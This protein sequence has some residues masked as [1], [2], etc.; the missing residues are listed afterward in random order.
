MMLISKALNYCLTLSE[1]ERMNESPIICFSDA[2]F[3]LS[4]SICSESNCLV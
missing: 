2:Y 4:P 1:N 3:D